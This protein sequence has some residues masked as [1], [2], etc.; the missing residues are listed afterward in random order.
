MAKKISVTVSHPFGF[1]YTLFAICTG[2]IGYNI[3]H[4][5]VGW[6]I[7]DALFAPLSW[8]KWLIC[9]QINVSMIKHTFDFFLQ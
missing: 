8:C 1:L 5:S 4:G 9:H 7:V 3:N 6:A 2:M